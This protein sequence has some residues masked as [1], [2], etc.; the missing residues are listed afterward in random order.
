VQKSEK[1]QNVE[2][3]L[4]APRIRVIPVVLF[5]TFGLLLNVSCRESI[6]TSS[7]EKPVV[8]S[9]K[10]TTQSLLGAAAD[11]ASK[12]RSG[13]SGFLLLDRGN[14]ALAWRTRLADAAESSIDAQ[15]FLWKN[16]DAGKIMMQRL[17]AAADR[18]VRVRVLVDD[19]M[20][21]SNPRYLATFGAHPNIA[22]RLY[23]PFGPK[24]KSL[25][26][27]WLDYASDLKILNRRMHNKVFVVDG[28]YAIVGGRNIGNEYF[29]YIGPF[30][31]RCRDL[32]AVGPVVNSTSS[33][34]DQYWNSDW[35]VPIEDVISSVPSLEK[36]QEEWGELAEFSTQ[37]DYYPDGFFDL[38]AGFTA[39]WESIKNQLYWGNARLL[40]DAVPPIK[41]QPENRLGFDQ[42]GKTLLKIM[43]QSEREVYI[44][45]AYLILLDGGFEALRAAKQRNVKV[46]LSTNSMASDNHLSA[47]VGYRKQRKQMI[48]TGADLF[49]MR[50]DDRSEEALFSPAL[51]KEYHTKF[52]LHAKTMVFDGR[53][54]FVG[55]FNVDPRSVNLNTEMGFLVDS[56]ELASAVASSIRNDIAPG[57]SWQLEL[58]PKGE[59][60]WVT[61]REGKI[62][63]ESKVEP[64]TNAAER[65]AADLLLVVPDKSQL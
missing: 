62:T 27:R 23:K 46:V 28:S 61:R 19:S 30:C 65:A 63:E 9:A 17:I 45:S 60:I 58:T 6:E 13:E 39:G 64:M 33:G 29:E 3:H 4:W 7:V 54:T 55:S 53:Y 47:F 25:V 31:F 22:V 35:T 40:I 8:E 5:A 50:P 18:G 41:G 56:R 12:N 20:T 51:V 59:I 49:E 38:P 24:G 43:N 36:S 26:M 11:L 34:F 48:E 21:E 1:V 57:N 32:M 52:G 37:K 15:Y 42:T 2:M 16:D 44:Q 14:Q 10:P